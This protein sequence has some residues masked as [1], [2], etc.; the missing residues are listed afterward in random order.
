MKINNKVWL[1]SGAASGLGYA[2]AAH[3]LQRGGRVAM[4][5]I[6]AGRLQQAQHQLDPHGDKSSCHVVDIS[7]HSHVQQLPQ[8]IIQHHGH[9]DGLINNAGI[10]QPFVDWYELA[11]QNMERILQINFWG[12]INL[13]TTFLPYLL[14]RPEA[15]LVN[16]ASMGGIFPF[17]GQTFYGASKAAVKLLTEGMYLELRHSPVRVTLV[18]PGAISTN[19]VQ[20]SGIE[21]P[22]T[23]ADSKSRSMLTADE[24]AKRIIHAVER[25]RYRVLVGSDAKWLELMYRFNPVW[26]I[27]FIARQI[28][29]QIPQSK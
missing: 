20:N 27:R 8:H 24:A 2:L 23:A 10:I 15:H 12:V 13:T 4:L 6:N 16:I 26:A 29:K 3:I 7:M 5:D 14:Q 1:V 18:I 9:I 25:N 11:R 22:K 28:A 21:P 19:I 17:P